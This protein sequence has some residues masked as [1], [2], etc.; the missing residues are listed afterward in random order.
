MSLSSEE[1]K[2][3][4][5]FNHQLLQSTHTT[6]D[7]ELLKIL[8]S[9]MIQ[10]Y[11]V[12]TLVYHSYQKSM[13]TLFEN[14]VSASDRLLLVNSALK[15]KDTWS[16]ANFGV[17]YGA[18][19]SS[20]CHMCYYE[21]VHKILKLVYARGNINFER[22]L[23]IVSLVTID[24]IM[25]IRSNVV[26]RRCLLND[27]T[28]AIY[29]ILHKLLQIFYL[30]STTSTTT[31]ESS[32][33]SSTNPATIGSPKP[34]KQYIDSIINML[35]SNRELGTFYVNIMNHCLSGQPSIAPYQ[36]VIKILKIFTMFNKSAH[37]ITEYLRVITYFSQLFSS[38]QIV[39]DQ[40]L[41][42][43]QQPQHLQQQAH[44]NQSKPTTNIVNI[45][46]GIATPSTSSSSLSFSTSTTTSSSAVTTTTSTATTT[47]TTTAS[48]MMSIDEKEQSLISDDND[49]DESES[50]AMES[51]RSTPSSELFLEGKSSTIVLSRFYKLVLEIINT[52]L[53]LAEDSRAYVNALLE[54]LGNNKQLIAYRFRI[55]QHA[56]IFGE[57]LDIEAVETLETLLSIFLYLENLHLTNNPVLE[58]LAN[59]IHPHLVFSYFI[60]YICSYDHTMLLDLLISS[61]ST[62]FLS[63]FLKYL[64]YIIMKPSSLEK[65]V[66]K[67]QRTNDQSSIGLEEIGK[68]TSSSTTTNTSTSTR[69]TSTASMR[70]TSLSS[71]TSSTTSTSTTTTSSSSSST[72]SVTPVDTDLNT[73][74]ESYTT[75][76]SSADFEIE[77][78]FYLISNCI[79][80]LSQSISKS[81]ENNSFPYNASLLLT[82]LR[83]AQDIFERINY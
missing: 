19:T 63:Y 26:G 21:T 80:K 70:S 29:S 12:S 39:L 34:F 24:F 35:S 57:N 43:Q 27:Q 15:L 56:S 8:S 17:G 11:K 1:L 20:D 60:E 82:R 69:S 44:N 28:P 4:L 64:N 51:L 76:T 10:Y 16:F 32:S 22:D 53:S 7:V 67:F 42:I 75:S 13:L 45:T 50:N 37:F 62:H 46:S 65:F 23:D 40:Q 38:S 2:E 25:Y 41:P 52:L 30:R 74:M 71:S 55:Q 78:D 72:S 81:H 36:I 14:S 79:S 73:S 33:S 77:Y 58:T 83:K 61:E 54:I 3:H 9:R 68:R 5:A 66:D 48:N 49:H 59:S 31:S 18:P 6:L 47:T